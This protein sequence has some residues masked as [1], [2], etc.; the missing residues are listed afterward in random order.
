ML[1]RKKVKLKEDQIDVKKIYKKFALC[2]YISYNKFKERR[3]KMSDMN[4]KNIK[5]WGLKKQ[6]AVGVS[7][8]LVIWI[9]WSLLGGANAATQ[10]ILQLPEKTIKVKNDDNKVSLDI[11]VGNSNSTYSGVNSQVVKNN[12]LYTASDYPAS[13]AFEIKGVKVPIDVALFDGNGKIIGVYD[14]ETGTEES[15]NPDSEYQYVLMAQ[16]GYFTGKNISKENNSRL[17]SDTLN[18]NS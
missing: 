8:I 1:Y 11:R 13:A 18:E 5:N 17:L 4:I 14:V 6:I 2:L 10:N 7:A 16:D 15:F 12:V 9:L 3:I